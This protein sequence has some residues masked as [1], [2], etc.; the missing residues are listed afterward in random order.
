[1]KPL[2]RIKGNAVV[3]KLVRLGENTLCVMMTEID[4]HTR[5]FF[6]LN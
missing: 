6:L 1:M 2:P 5:V 3:H 4:I